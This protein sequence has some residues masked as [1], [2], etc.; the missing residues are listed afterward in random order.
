LVEGVPLFIDRE[1][2]TGVPHIIDRRRKKV[3]PLLLPSSR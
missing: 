1:D 3:V 2:E